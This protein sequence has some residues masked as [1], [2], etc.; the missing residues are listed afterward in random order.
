MNAECEYMHTQRGPWSALLYPLSILFIVLAIFLPD[1][2]PRYVFLPVGMMLTVLAAG[3][4]YLTVEDRG[5]Y[6]WIHFGPLPLFSKRIEYSEIVSVE[7]GRTTLLDGW[8]IHLS[9]RGGWVWNIWGWHCVVIRLRHRVFFL[10]TDDVERLMSHLQG[11]VADSDHFE[12]L[13]V[14]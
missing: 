7:A 4:H 10:G 9:L 1:F 6:L 11:K 2:P 13:I 5:T 3:V 14:T 12:E 8:G